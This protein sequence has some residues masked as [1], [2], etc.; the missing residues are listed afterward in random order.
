MREDHIISIIAI[1]ISINPI[2]QESCEQF[3]RQLQDANTTLPP[4]YD[5]TILS[6]SEYRTIN[7]AVTWAMASVECRASM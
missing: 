7:I 5:L 4:Y 3:E 1:D 2:D 6:S